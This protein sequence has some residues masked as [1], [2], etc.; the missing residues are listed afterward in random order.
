MSEGNGAKVTKTLPP[1]AMALL[2]EAEL[3]VQLAQERFQHLITR[4]EAQFGVRLQGAQIA[5]D[6]TVTEAKQPEPAP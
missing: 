2:R 3:R 6:G 4:V 5:E 1:G